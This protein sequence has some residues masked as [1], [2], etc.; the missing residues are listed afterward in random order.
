M[1]IRFFRRGCWS[2]DGQYFFSP[3]A[4]Y[5]NDNSVHVYATYIFSRNNMNDPVAVIPSPHSPSIC[6]RC[7]SN[8][9][10][11]NELDETEDKILDINYR[12]IFAIATNESV[13]IYDTSK[14]QPLA[15]ISDIHFDEIT[16]LAWNNEGNILAI[17]SKDGYCSFIHFEVSFGVIQE[18]LSHTENL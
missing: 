1:Y 4:I 12:F 18:D 15:F 5:K 8:I 2:P 6:I 13:T 3:C 17:S 9:L 14:K 16:D 10:Q 7:N 11:L